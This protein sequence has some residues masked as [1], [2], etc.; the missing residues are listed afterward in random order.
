MIQKC[1]GLKGHAWFFVRTLDKNAISIR[2]FKKIS[3]RIP[4][5]SLFDGNG[6]F[7]MK[8]MLPFNGMVF[9]RD[10]ESE[11]GVRW[12]LGLGSSTPLQFWGLGVRSRI[13]NQ[14]VER[15]LGVGSSTILGLGRWESDSLTI[16][17]TG[18]WCRPKNLSTPHPWFLIVHSLS[19]I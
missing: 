10:V 3:I 12:L 17:G 13:K 18:S 7:C 19:K 2:I 5:F 9:N 16:L 6:K 14:D 15:E 1:F 8:E 11:L 4:F